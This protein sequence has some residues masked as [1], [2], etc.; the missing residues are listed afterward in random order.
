MPTLANGRTWQAWVLG[1]DAPAPAG[2]ATGGG[3]V[4]ITLTAPLGPGEGVAVTQEP[5][6]GSKA[7]TSTPVLV[8]PRSF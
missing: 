8:L 2:L 3:I 4:T 7:P 6:G 1:A 5:A